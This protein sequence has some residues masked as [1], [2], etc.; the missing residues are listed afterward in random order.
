MIRAGAIA[1]LVVSLSAAA[2]AQ[3]PAPDPPAPVTRATGEPAS[4]AIAMGGVV[5]AS[6][7]F[8]LML[9]QTAPCYCGPATAWVIGGVAVVAAGLTITWLGLR[10]RTVTIAPVVAP[11]TAGGLAVIRWGG[12]SRRSSSRAP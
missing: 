5:L 2:W 9:H 7:G 1:A 6:A 8:G 11:H 3:D 10:P 4:L 12:P